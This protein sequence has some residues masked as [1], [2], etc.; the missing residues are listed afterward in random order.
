MNTRK[1]RRTALLLATLSSA[2]ASASASATSTALYEAAGNRAIFQPSL[3]LN[4]K[5]YQPTWPNSATFAAMSFTLSQQ[6]SVTGA[7]LALT[8][9]ADWS[10]N[11]SVQILGDIGGM[12]G[13]S[14]VWTAS[15]QN[16]I[17]ISQGLSS[18]SMTSV[19][20]DAVL[21]E[22]NTKYWLYVS[23]TANCQLAWWGDG[24]NM[25]VATRDNS[26]TPYLRWSVGEGTAAMFRITGSISTVPEANTWAMMLAGVGWRCNSTQE[27]CRSL[28]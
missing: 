27:I 16:P 4:I 1:M 17:P 23:C 28:S 19:S 8:A 15:S 3:G 22:A 9:L 13:P 14:P 20:G 26:V 7:E 18:Y 21:L 2:L 10:S 25:A 6:S 5:D 24:V 12:P 11:Y